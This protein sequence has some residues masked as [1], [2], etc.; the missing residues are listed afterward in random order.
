MPRKLDLGRINVRGGVIKDRIR[1][2]GIYG[3]GDS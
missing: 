2:G 1:G 3:L